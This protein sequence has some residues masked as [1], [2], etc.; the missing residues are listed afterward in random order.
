MP[1]GK[2][3]DG[4]DPEEST[5]R[6][7][8]EETKLESGV[9]SKKASPKSERN[10]EDSEPGQSE[11]IQKEDPFVEKLEENLENLGEKNE[12]LNPKEIE[13][14]QN[15]SALIDVLNR[16][17]SFLLGIVLNKYNRSG[18]NS[19]RMRVN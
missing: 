5:D 17:V 12:A 6:E 4:V 11:E 14:V 13:Q 10:V 15:I 2:Q 16:T 19:T 9:S 7:T 1:G 3:Y 8:Q 18:L